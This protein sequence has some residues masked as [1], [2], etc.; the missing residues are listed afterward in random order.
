MLIGESFGIS[1]YTQIS[2]NA[3]GNFIGGMLNSGFSYNKLIIRE[4]R[5]TN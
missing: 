1:F 5:Y 2:F 4:L 3:P